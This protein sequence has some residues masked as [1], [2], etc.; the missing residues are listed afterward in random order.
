MTHSAM[1]FYSIVGGALAM[2]L[3]VLAGMAVR[4]AIRRR[5]AD[6]LIRMMEAEE[7]M[8]WDEDAVSEAMEEVERNERVDKGKG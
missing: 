8:G 3:V 4:N 2:C 7:W 1:L 6:K 5:E